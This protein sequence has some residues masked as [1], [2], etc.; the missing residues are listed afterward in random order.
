MFFVQEVA[1]VTIQQPSAVL[2]A[3]AGS[4]TGPAA[5]ELVLAGTDRLDL[6]TVAPDGSVRLIKSSPVFSVVRRVASFRRPGTGGRLEGGVAWADVV[7]NL[8]FSNIGSWHVE[9]QRQRTALD[10]RPPAHT[11][12]HTHS[13]SLLV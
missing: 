12:T 4:F 3:V 5:V 10:P 13:L 8:A 2:T 6:F 11:C 7:N 9:R 1:Y